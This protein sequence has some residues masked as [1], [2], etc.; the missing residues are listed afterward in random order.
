MVRR[1]DH[2]HILAIAASAR[3]E[4]KLRLVVD[5]GSAHNVHRHVHHARDGGL[6]RRVD[7]RRAALASNVVLGVHANLQLEKVADA[8]VGHRHVGLVVHQHLLLL[9]EVEQR[10]HRV[11][12]RALHQTQQLGLALQP[13]IGHNAGAR[14]GTLTLQALAPQR[15][16][17]I[18]GVL[19]HL[20][21][22]QD[23]EVAHA[24]VDLLNAQ[25]EE[26][27]AVA[28]HEELH[29]ELNTR[30]KRRQRPDAVLALKGA[31][32]H[33]AANRAAVGQLR[34]EAHARRGDGMCIGVGQRRN[35]TRA[36][37]DGLLV[38]G[39]EDHLHLHALLDGSHA[40]VASS[41]HGGRRRR[42][43]RQALLSQRAH[44][45]RSSHPARLAKQVIVGR[46]VVVHA[47]I[48]ARA[49]RV[50]NAVV[51]KR[52][53]RWC[54]RNRVTSAQRRKPL[55]TGMF[56]ANVGHHLPPR[57]LPRL[58]PPPRRL[59]GPPAPDGRCWP[60]TTRLIAVRANIGSPVYERGFAR[61][62]AAA[63]AAR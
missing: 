13:Q 58:E 45:G 42:H 21:G 24:N 47:T 60:A 52:L 50:G 40:R 26:H 12:A 8:V 4:I 53:H 49:G 38:L 2:G 57:P 35:A 25:A 17:P 59:P 41:I 46:L 30:A 48:H 39:G 62:M 31:H 15:R 3:H 36:Q 1:H 44:V 9:D 6:G 18:D 5:D 34:V 27:G 19:Q 55:I 16:R 22:Q 33:T 28:V 63:M 23:E 29:G 56:S 54:R 10:L 43:G 32:A 11:D 20:V 37:H 61:E 14:L 7:Q 51:E